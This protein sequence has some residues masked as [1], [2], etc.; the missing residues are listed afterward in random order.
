MSKPDRIFRQI[1]QFGST[2]LTHWFPSHMAKGM[3]KM[4]ATLKK[5][6]LVVEVHDARIPIAGRNTILKELMGV[7]PSLLVL[8]KMDLADLDKTKMII[9]NL[10]EER[11][12]KQMMF[13][14]CLTQHSRSAKKVMPKIVEIIES[15]ERYNRDEEV[16]YS[17]LCTGIP[18]V[19]KSSLI[20]AMRRLHLKKGRGTSTAPTP[21][22]TRSVLHKI[23]V[24]ERPTIWLYDTPGV[25]TPQIQHP[26]IGMKLAVCGTIPDHRVGIDIICDYLLYILNKQ[27]IHK[28]VEY[29]EL[30]SPTDDIMQVLFHIADKQKKTILLKTYDGSVVRRP[31]MFRAADMMLRAFR[32]GELGRVTLD[33]A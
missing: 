14:E 23:K 3:K 21:G 24:N 4:M 31:D 26:D 18:N 20:N 1:F 25:L 9:D 7:R 6:D 12:N 22:V 13:C 29:F 27:E 11:E 17:I 8:N 33:D 19:G 15:S 5:V 10:R 2:D 30:D 16:E 28:Y 32:K